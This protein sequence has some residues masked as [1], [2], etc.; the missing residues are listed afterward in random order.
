VRVETLKSSPRTRCDELLDAERLLRTLND[1]AQ[2]SFEERGE[3]AFADALGP[4][5]KNHRDQGS[6]GAGIAAA[7]CQ[8]GTRQKL[9]GDSHPETAESKIRLAD[10]M[11]ASGSFHGEPDTLIH[12]AFA[13]L[14]ERLLVPNPSVALAY[15]ALA[16][17]YET[18]GEHLAAEL[19]FRRGLS[20]YEA[21]VGAESGLAAQA[22]RNVGRVLTKRGGMT[23]AELVLGQ[24]LERSRRAFGQ[25]SGEVADCLGLLSDCAAKSDPSKAESLARQALE[26]KLEMR[27]DNQSEI[28]TALNGVADLRRIQ[29]D[30]EEAA[31]L[32]RRAAAIW[33][34]G[35]PPNH[36]ALALAY[37]RV[38][39]C[40][41]REG[42]RAE[43]ESLRHRALEIARD[44][45]G[46]D[47]YQTI[48]IRSGLGSLMYLQGNYAVAETTLTAAASSYERVRGQA[49]TDLDEPFSL[50]S[51]YPVL[52]LTLL[53]QGRM[54][55]AW[56]AY[57]RMDADYVLDRVT[58]MR[59]ARFNRRQ[60]EDW[61]RI[62]DLE[63]TLQQR[64]KVL[65]RGEATTELVAI[66]G[67][68]KDS[69]D[70]LRVEKV[71]LLT[72]VVQQHPGAFHEVPNLDR[73]QALLGGNAALIGWLDIEVRE[74]YWESWG[75][76]ISNRGPVHW[77]QIGR[78]S[79][80]DLAGPDWI[81]VVLNLRNG[82]SEPSSSGPG[83][84]D[85]AAME[86]YRQRVAPAEDLLE[87]VD[88][89]IA[90]PSRVMQGIPL[91]ALMTASGRFLGE[92][93]TVSYTPSPAVFV[94]MNGAR[95]RVETPTSPQ[96][97]LFVADP[98]YR[99]EHVALL[100]LDA[101]MDAGSEP[102]ASIL[103]A[104]PADVVRHALAG[105]D[106]ALGQ[107]PRVP[108]T[109]LEV[110]TAAS[111]IPD[112]TMLL[113]KDASEQKLEQLVDTGE[114]G[115]FDIIH[116]GAHA[117]IDGRQPDQS[118]LVL[119]RVDLPD[120]LEAAVSGA[121]VYD[122]LLSAAEIALTWRVGA[123][124]VVLSAC[125]TGL[126]RDDLGGS[127]VGLP[128]AFLRAGAR[129]LLVSL[130]SVDDRATAVLIDSFYRHWLRSDTSA[131][132]VR[133]SLTKAEALRRGQEDVRHYERNGSHPYQHPY[134]WAG[135]VLYGEP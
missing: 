84:W 105:E 117:L 2:L 21:T 35:L 125:E 103:K 89:L 119:S 80:G 20:M 26:I 113:G 114:I 99:P 11:L 82:L 13:S 95:R 133:P 127:F 38:A 37:G 62:L 70:R 44:N 55:D 102:T 4:Q 45:W 112:P 18:R 78:G 14:T 24:A 31:R 41:E 118:A 132:G 25:R 120:P 28:G 128:V 8:L 75:Y 32:E 15:S 43:A 66:H 116:L 71:D 33:E 40:L 101:S 48:R 1:A 73:V 91:E 121:R 59:V 111:F 49:G 124:L 69:L 29:G 104:M 17:L 47:H 65:G 27:G 81:E 7:R 107:L 57:A 9:L 64:L 109:R 129:S 131:A 97:G 60:A 39:F 3:L 92:R 79:G 96:R 126:V 76:V 63:W 52:A 83:G 12:Q 42:L 106:S 87:G 67:A 50:E 93:L 122:G 34:R 16:S 56:H 77:F 5:I 51:P 74:N 98:S 72:A 22:M 58:N 134:Y 88:E 30:Y 86:L 61:H 36:P 6:F 68:V 46:D 53:A 85:D 90:V 10:L 94:W 110:A 54:E 100:D 115:T 130:W 19:Y 135:F 123:Q 108:F 23:D